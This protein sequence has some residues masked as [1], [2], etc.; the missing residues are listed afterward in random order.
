MHKCLNKTCQHEHVKYCPDCGKVY[1]ED[2]G[3]EWEDRQEYAHY[4]PPTPYVTYTI[5]GDTT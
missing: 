4:P 3:K 1:C 5:S 2:C